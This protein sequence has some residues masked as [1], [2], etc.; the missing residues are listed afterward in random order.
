MRLRTTALPTFLET[1]KPTRT[2]PVSDSADAPRLACT[3]T[4]GR[5]ARTPSRTVASNCL[6]ERIRN[7]A[8]ST[9]QADSSERPLRRRAER[10]A[11]PARV[12]M[13]AR[14]PWVRERRRLLGWNVRLLKGSL[15]RSCCACFG[16]SRSWLLPTTA[17]PS[18]LHRCSY[19]QRLTNVTPLAHS[20]AKALRDLKWRRRPVDTP[21]RTRIGPHSLACPNWNR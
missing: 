17:R 19:W 7:G 15:R 16:R 1:T 21:R 12:F 6:D 5:P 11:R 20:S 13:R 4:V 18:G 10:I 9:C 2:C 14:K 8:G 3:T